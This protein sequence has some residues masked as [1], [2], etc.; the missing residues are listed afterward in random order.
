VHV[1]EDLP[2]VQVRWEAGEEVQPGGDPFNLG[3]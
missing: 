3:V 2:F 1:A